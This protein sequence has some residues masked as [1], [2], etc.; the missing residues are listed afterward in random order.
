MNLEIDFLNM[1]DARKSYKQKLIPSFITHHLVSSIMQVGEISFCDR[2]GFNINSDEVKRSILGDLEK[3]YGI[4]I[5]AK[6]Y[7]KFDQK[8]SIPNLQRNPHMICL[9][10]NGNPYFLHL[11]RYNFV[12]YCIFIDKKIQQGYYFPRMI[13]TRLSF[14]DTLFDD[15][16]TLL[17]GEMIKGSDSWYFGFV[18]MIVHQGKHLGEVN[19]PKRLNL[20][21]KLLQSR[22]IQ[23]DTD[24]CRFFIKKYFSYDQYANI[25]AHI[26]KL[27]YTTRGLIFRPL[28][29]RFKDTL[30]NFDDSLIVKV[31]RK[32]IGTFVENIQTLPPQEPKPPQAPT[33]TPTPHLHQPVIT[34]KEQPFLAQ[35]TNVPDVYILYDSKTHVEI[36]TAC[37]QSLSISKKM[38]ELFANKNSIDKIPLTCTFS[39]RFH[40]W[41]PVL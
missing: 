28:F 17:E 12:Q 30:L 37:I 4:K 22:F 35:K 13:V 8:R 24:V 40:K 3:S 15:G 6:H 29:M 1:Q 26:D 41:V 38:R 5:I 18:D 20:L 7:E 33:G 27:P 25:Q 19:L 39:E 11:V 9:R 21:Y 34:S 23:D 32:K 14:D 31:E 16:G 2:I 36:G 10:S